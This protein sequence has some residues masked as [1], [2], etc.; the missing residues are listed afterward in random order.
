ME[1]LLSTDTYIILFLLPSPPSF[2]IHILVSTTPTT[3]I[4][5]SSPTNH[6]MSELHR[7]ALTVPGSGKTISRKAQSRQSSAASSR[8]ASRANSRTA[9]RVNTDD[10]G[11]MSDDTNLRC[12]FFFF[13]L[14]SDSSSSSSSEP[15]SRRSA[16]AHDNPPEE[17]HSN[18]LTTDTETL[19]F[20]SVPELTS[21][22]ELLEPGHDWQ[23]ELAATIERLCDR[24]KTGYQ[25]REDALSSYVNTLSARFAKEEIAFRR[26]E[27]VSSCLRSVKAGR[28]ERESLL[29][30]KALGLTIITDPTEDVYDRVSQVFKTV[31]TDHDSPA[32]KAAVLHHLGVA[33][34]YGGATTDE[35]IGIMDFF[36]EIVQS[37]GHSVGAGDDAGVVTAA[38][39]EWGFLCTQLE[40]AEEVTADS[41]DALVEQLESSEVSVQVA[42]GENIALLY[43][44]SYTEAE[45][46]E[47]DDRNE[48]G[49]KWVQRYTPY[50]RTDALKATLAGLS[51]GSRR[52]L[53]KRNKKTQRSAFGDILH[54]LDDPL[55]GPRFSEALDRNGAVKGSRLTVRVH[56][57]GVLRVDKWWK[58]LRLQHLRRLL[59]GGFLT[60]WVDNPV[61]FE[62]LRYECFFPIRV[63]SV[64]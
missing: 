37:D 3:T 54:S 43:E 52:Y 4:Y 44:K 23:D 19:S 61:I 25:A 7:K 59:G 36:L 48:I 8:V 47:V 50:G 55:K 57:T 51:S 35:T 38:L 28:T 17:Y 63:G 32:V 18:L 30:A 40:D 12:V 6:A 14:F 64:C 10:E 33:A 29:A 2:S 20:G 24:R 11:D 1:R 9:S 26:D 45:E 15:S 13:F 21:F 31:I 60:H 62:S 34:F 53:S 41:I 27:I 5:H 22:D 58:L 16:L 42:A 46:D 49:T 56:K 39:E